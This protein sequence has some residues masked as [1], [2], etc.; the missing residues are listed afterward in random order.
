M[1][2]TTRSKDNA[3]DNG[4]AVDQN[5]SV[6]NDNWLWGQIIG[7]VPPASTGGMVK[8][9]VQL[10]GMVDATATEIFTVTTVNEAGATDG[11][12]WGAKFDGIG[13]HGAGSASENAVAVLMSQTFAKAMGND[14]VGLA[15]CTALDESSYCSS[16]AEK[17]IVNFAWTVVETSEYVTSCRCTLDIGGTAITTGEVCGMVTLFYKGFTTAPVITSA[18]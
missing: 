9:W 6:D 10:S 18:G 7:P 17:T 11:G 14:G 1:P 16:G 15:A 8:Q 3:G 5:A 12:V 2:F 4:R 13:I